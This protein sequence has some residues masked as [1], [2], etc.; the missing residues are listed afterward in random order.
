M[1]Q[2]VSIVQMIWYLTPMHAQLAPDPALA[3]RFV[4]TA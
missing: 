4:L 1:K 2:Y 3:H